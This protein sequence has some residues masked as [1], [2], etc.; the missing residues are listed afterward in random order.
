M[1]LFHQ[2]YVQMGQR[3]GKM[4]MSTLLPEEYRRNLGLPKWMESC[5]IFI[6]I[7]TYITG[8][9]ISGGEFRKG[10]KRN[11]CFAYGFNMER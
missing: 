9:L 6:F 8:R 3:E 4:Y 10:L 11:Y 1:E 5:S 2:A 7:E